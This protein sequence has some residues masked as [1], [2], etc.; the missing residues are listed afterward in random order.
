[1]KDIRIIFYS[2][3][4]PANL[5]L[6]KLLPKKAALSIPFYASLSES[7]STPEYDPY[8]LDITLKQ[9]MKQS[10]R[11]ERDSIRK[12]AVDFIS[13]KTVSVTNVHKNRT[14]NKKPKPWDIEN[15][16]LSYSF[17]KT[18]AHNPLIEYN[19][20]T[21]QRAGLG[22]NFVAQPKFFEPLKKI[23][24]KSKTHWFDLDKGF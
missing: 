9:K 19:N 8:D 22:Y 20:V 14:N 24:K 4:P 16:D 21:K 10:P 2:L 1:M 3:T 17:T 6:G 12:N 5:E 23:F 11:S 7:I 13:T 15:F 18:E